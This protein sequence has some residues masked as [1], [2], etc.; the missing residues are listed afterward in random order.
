M[1]LDTRPSQDMEDMKFKFL[2]KLSSQT[3][4]P[5]E[6]INSDRTQTVKFTD[7]GKSYFFVESGLGYDTEFPIVLRYDSR[8]VPD[9]EHRPIVVQLSLS[10]LGD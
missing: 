10:F 8:K 6:I 5:F 4:S 7:R 2:Y 1:E 3:E 9:V